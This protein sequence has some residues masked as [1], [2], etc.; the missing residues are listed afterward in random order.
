MDDSSSP[1]DGFSSLLRLS[2]FT[3]PARARFVGEATFT[4]IYTG[5]TFGLVFGQ[6]GML[7]TPFGPLLPFLF[8]SSFGFCIGLYTTWK[9][10]VQ[11]TY[12]YANHYPH[13]LAHAL[14][15]DSRIIV[16]QSVLPTTT[17]D[18]EEHIGTTSAGIAT[19]SLMAEWVKCQGLREFSLCVLAAQ[20]CQKDVNEVDCMVRQRLIE[21]TSSSRATS[22]T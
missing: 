14:W 5:T 8:G 4:G 11:I 18:P 20:T 22:N 10:A 7:M 13:I 2:G 21:E 19:S 15:T 12:T 17:L 16:P 9:N 3:V 6:L 1:F